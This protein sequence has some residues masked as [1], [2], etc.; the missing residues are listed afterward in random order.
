VG[1]ETERATGTYELERTDRGTS[2]NRKRNQMSDKHSPPGERGQR[3]KSE[4]ENKPSERRA[5][6]DWR[7]QTEGQV[8][9]GKE[10]KQAT[11]THQ[12]ESADGGTSQSGKRNRASN[13]HSQTG[14]HR[15]RAKSESEKKLNERRALTNW[16][17]QIEREK[18]EHE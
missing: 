10:T 6:T 15:Q 4:W 8:R 14:E 16:R 13:G 17:V 18:W 2:Q 1:K 5:L 3:D 12:L 11:G 7:A 9:I